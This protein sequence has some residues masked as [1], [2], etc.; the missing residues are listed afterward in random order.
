[1]GDAYA[2]NVGFSALYFDHPI[3]YGSQRMMTKG[4]MQVTD[5]HEQAETGQILVLT[6]PSG[7]PKTLT[8]GTRA[9][10]KGGLSIPGPS[11]F[12]EA[13]EAVEE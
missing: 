3:I 11:P 10:A 7:S 1:M 12:P 4:V 8:A 5:L 13:R 2:C 9:T 6:C